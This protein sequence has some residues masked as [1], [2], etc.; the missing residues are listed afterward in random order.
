MDDKCNFAISDF[1]SC[2]AIAPASGEFKP[3]PYLNI[4][5]KEIVESENYTSQKLLLVDNSEVGRFDAIV[6]YI[7]T[8]AIDHPPVS[9]AETLKRAICDH[10]VLHGME[11]RKESTTAAGYDDGDL[12]AG[13]GE[14]RERR[15]TYRHTLPVNFQYHTND[16]NAKRRVF[17]ENKRDVSLSL[18]QSLPTSL[19]PRYLASLYLLTSRIAKLFKGKLLYSK[20]ILRVN[21]KYSHG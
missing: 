6:E 13:D 9:V 2:C 18:L 3:T 7:Y 11:T 1:Q 19:L 20:I 17:L 8:F 12:L 10:I 5:A 14:N 15:R 4:T 16:D 21:S